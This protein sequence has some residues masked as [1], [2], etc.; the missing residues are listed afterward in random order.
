MLATRGKSVHI[1]NAGVSG[2]TNA[3][4]LSRLD[5]AVP[6]G[7]K[8]VLLDRFGG[9][10]NARRLGRKPARFEAC[11][12]LTNNIKP[13]RTSGEG[14]PICSAKSLSL[15]SAYATCERIRNQSIRKITGS[16]SSITIKKRRM[17]AV[18]RLGNTIGRDLLHQRKMSQLT[19]ARNEASL[20]GFG[21]QRSG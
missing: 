17:D 11:L 9:G 21:L 6:D 8:F 14:G 4:M 7:T 19:A 10:W 2:D 13:G 12:G 15:D 5:S 20:A 16:T 18:V 1:A 3:G